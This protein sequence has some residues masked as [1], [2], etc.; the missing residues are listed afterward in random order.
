MKGRPPIWAWE[1]K[2]DLRHNV[3]IGKGEKG[4]RLELEVPSVELLASNFGAWHCVLNDH[5]LT[6][7]DAETDKAF[8]D[9]GYTRDQIESSWQ[10][11]FDLDYCTSVA[12]YGS[13]VQL[14]MPA[15]ELHYMKKAQA[16][17][18]R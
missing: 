7:T 18:G 9:D 5:Y 16:F 1:K 10:K 12:G 13:A 8:S 11:V 6:S 14:T 4:V 2:P 3:H 17:R 15:L